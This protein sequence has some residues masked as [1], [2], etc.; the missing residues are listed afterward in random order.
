MAV[1][2][3]DADVILRQEVPPALTPETRTGLEAA[4]LH[5]T[6]RKG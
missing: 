2:V 1:V 4:T 3:W 5:V 6:T